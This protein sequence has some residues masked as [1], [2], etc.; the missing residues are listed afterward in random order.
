MG[1][2]LP[3]ASGRW[4]SDCAQAQ[5]A[6]AE[7]LLTVKVAPVASHSYCFSSPGDGGEEAPGVAAGGA[8]GMPG[9]IDSR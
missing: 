3:D 1:Q 7:E 9:Y 6:V 4:G 2:N 5:R 8:G